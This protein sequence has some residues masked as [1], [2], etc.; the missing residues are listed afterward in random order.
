MSIQVAVKPEVG[1]LEELLRAARAGEQ[2]VP[3]EFALDAKTAVLLQQA[4]DRAAIWARELALPTKRDEEWR[5]TDL[6]ALTGVHFQAPLPV[7]VEARAIAP[8]VLPEAAESRLV[9]VN[10]VY[11][12]HLSAVAG[13]PEGAI[14]GNLGQLPEQ[15][16]DR[17]EGYLA[18]HPSSNEAF[19]ALNTAGLTDAAVV[20]LPR[21]AIVETPIHLLFLSVAAEASVISQPRCLVVAEAGSS[22]TIVEYYS[23]LETLGCP[24][25]SSG[26]YLANAVTE[27]WLE[28]N[29][30][31]V[32][33]RVQREASEAFHI[34]KT[35]IAQ[36]RNSRYTGYAV[37]LGAVLSRHNWE[38]FQT[39]EGTETTLNGLSAIAGE[40][41]ADT[42]SAIALNHPH[43]TCR[44]LH[45]CI[46]NDRARAVF[47]GKIFVPKPAQMTDAAQLSR[48]L[49]LSPKARVDTK[50][51]LEITAD[52]VKCSHGATVS[53][54][55]AEEVFYLQSRGLS[56]EM[57]CNLLIDAFATEIIQQIPIASLQKML[58][59]CVACRQ[60]D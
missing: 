25:S 21:N 17:L 36:A 22:A 40:Q 49:L 39:G 20:W 24:G 50:P 44:Q 53:Q 15:Y 18:K 12:P 59:R 37:S 55:D 31:V 4:R 58:S 3:P 60:I 45:K 6:S 7:Q 5:F 13:L 48:N 9:F 10:G 2:V 56:R 51:Q 47:N 28:E 30:E 26:S 19:A 41:L 38:V 43:G 42:H 34:G 52:N 33:V 27:L 35:A 57:S 54:L 23:T 29:A 1:Y 32:H 14:A 46:V 16:R 8:L 11:A